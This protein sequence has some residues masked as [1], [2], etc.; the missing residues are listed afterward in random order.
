MAL[1]SPYTVVTAPVEASAAVAA[2]AADVKVVDDA[3]DASW[4]YLRVI[5]QSSP[6]S[7]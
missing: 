3:T 4:H 1:P 6:S 7:S 5:H 2:A